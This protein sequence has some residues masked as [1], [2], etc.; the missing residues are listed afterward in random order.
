MHSKTSEISDAI[1]DLSDL[2]SSNDSPIKINSEDSAKD[3]ILQ[4]QR[5]ESRFEKIIMAA[6]SYQLL[7]LVSLV[8]IYE[9]VFHVGEGLSLDPK[10]NIKNVKK[11]GIEFMRSVLNINSK[12]E[13]RNRLGCER[14]RDLFNM[15]ITS[16]QL[17]QAGCRKCDFFVKK[18]YYNVFLSQVNPDATPPRKK[19]KVVC[20]K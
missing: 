3:R 12:A 8:E 15:G 9:E 11:W 19:R 14:L 7:H 17:V 18:E 20:E 4:W 16:T 5:E 1:S 6:E 10:N 13:Q 2:L